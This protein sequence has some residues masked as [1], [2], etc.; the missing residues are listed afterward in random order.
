M[1][2]LTPLRRNAALIALALGGFAIGVTEF[3]SMG[4]LPNIAEDLLPD[5]AQH[6]AQEIS[7]AG[8]LITLYALGV[9]VGAPI[10]TAL[11]ARASQTTLAFWLLGLFIVGSLA[12]ALAPSFETLAI[13]RFVAGLPHATYFGA[14]ALLA[15]SLMGPGNQGK[16]IAI[17]MSGL[18]IANIIGVPL[19]TWIGQSIGW[20][21]AYGLV[22]VLFA[23][24]LVLMLCFIPR[25]AGNPSLSVRGSLAGFKNIRVWIMLAVAAIGFGGFFAVYSYIA[26]V[27]TR[28]TELPPG[29]IPFVLATIGIGMT[30]GTFVGG[31]ASDR[32][33]ASTILVSFIAL[34]AALMLYVAIA[35]TPAGLFISV[36]LIGFW[37]SA[38]NPPVQARFIRIARDAELMGA[39]ASHAGFNIGNALG[40]WLGG[41]VIA[42]GYGY[43]APGWIGMVLVAIGAIFTLVSIGLSKRDRARSIDTTG[44]QL[45]AIGD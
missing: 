6:P 32:F 34:I 16:G 25:V 11:A 30:I 29:A 22:A 3:A 35:A 1:S 17:A 7:R 26:E 10:I 36:F 13:A 12:S 23:L 39:A 8:I 43:L 27:V 28:V 9:V 42:A 40:A 41:V 5:F 31:W 20:R 14:A 2:T 37:F 45:P 15:A 19:A 4:V 38:L 18:P 24:T 21:W 44:I 33:G